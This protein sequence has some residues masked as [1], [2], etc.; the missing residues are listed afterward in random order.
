MRLSQSQFCCLP[1]VKAP[2]VNGWNYACLAQPYPQSTER[3]RV[4]GLLKKQKGAPLN[5]G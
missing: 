5:L 2:K 1:T 4:K 3:A